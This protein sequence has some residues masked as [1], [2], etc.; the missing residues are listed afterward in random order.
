GLEKRTRV[1]NNKEKKIVAYHEIG[2]A[3]AALSLPGSDKVRKVSII[4]RGIGALGYTLQSPLEDRYLMT[5]E[6]L[7]NKIIILLGGRAS[8][9]VFFGKFSTGSSD[10]IAKAT[11]IARGIALKYGMIEELGHVSYEDP[12]EKFLDTGAYFSGHKNYS[13]KV[14][15][16][17]DRTIKELIDVAF[18]KATNIIINNRVAIEMAAK[19]LLIKETLSEDD[20]KKYL[21]SGL[22]SQASRPELNV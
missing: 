5:N 22:R 12:T 9:K 10:D 18:E 15:E 14:A 2:H 20:L 21:V 13:E 8:E 3:F 17:I 4:P 1:L 6:E 19:D 7:E 11:Q 16:N